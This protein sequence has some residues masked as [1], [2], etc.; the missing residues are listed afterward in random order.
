MNTHTIELRTN[1]L[2][3]FTEELEA[4][5][6]ASYNA[7][8]YKDFK[9]LQKIERYGRVAT[10][11]GYAT[12][13]IIPNPITAFCLSLGQFTRWLLMHHIS[14]RGYDRVP[15]IPKRYTSKYFARGWRRFIDWFD[16]VHPAAWEY[17]H[18]ILHHY[19]TGEDTDPDVAERHTEFL[20]ALRVPYWLKHCVVFLASI[21]WKYTY[22]AP[23]TMSCLD[24]ESK[25]RL[26]KD[27][28]AYIT[29]KNVFDLRNPHVRKLWLVCYL[30]YG[31]FHFVLIPACFLPLGSVAAFFVLVNKIL[32][33]CITNFHSFMVIGP[34]HTADD[35][36]RFDFHYKNKA[37]FY[38][39]QILGSANYRT[40]TE[41]LDYMSIW[42][43]YQIEHHLFPDLPMR[44]YREIQPAVKALCEKYKIP[45]KQ[46]SIF[47]RFSRMTA[48]CVGK[49]S[50]KTLHEFPL[51]LDHAELSN[52]DV[53][54]STSLSAY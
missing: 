30:P 15:G 11:L 43:N 53:R 24:P 42:L 46:E 27:H 40:G 36:F 22:Y 51:V 7:I 48:V 5:G 54:D 26:R 10:F 2:T 21:S 28:I 47:K 8:S 1:E 12:A 20:R 31:M 3:S 19:H 14:H 29:I 4:L 44:K 35:L 23:N 50:M 37:E 34:N 45:Y 17:E 32:A 18:N 49:S 33:E 9:H 41:F 38:V 25:K 16:W 52:R 13:W 39:T 6:A